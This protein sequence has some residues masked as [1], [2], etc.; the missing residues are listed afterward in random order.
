MPATIVM[1]G[2]WGDEGKGKLTDAL[3]GRAAMVVRANGGANAGHTVET[4]RG[5]FKLHLVPSGILNPDC[6]CVIGPGVVIDPAALVDEMDALTARGVDLGKLRIADRAHVVLPYHPLLDRLEESRRADDEIGTTLRGNGPAY[7]DKVARR[8]IRIAD[9][10][11]E[12]ALLRK[13]TR[14]VGVKN[15]ILTRVYGEPALDPAELFARMQTLG[16]RLREHVVPAEVLVQDALADGGDVVIECAQGAMLDVDY[17]TYPYVRGR[18]WRR[19]RSSGCWP[20]SRP[21]RPASAA[22]RCQPSC[23]TRSGGRSGSEVAST[24][25]PPAARAGPAGST[26]LPPATSYG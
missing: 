16:T 26:P 20:S 7:A 19:P 21:T 2:Q 14:E 17:G 5:V 12:A 6:V 18:A 11:D 22:V 9:L 25:R 8:G 23:T 13:L 15:Q 24:G 10:V 4:E 1:G 3:A